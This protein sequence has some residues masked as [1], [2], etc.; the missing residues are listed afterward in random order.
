MVDVRRYAFSSRGSVPLPSERAFVASSTI[1]VPRPRGKIVGLSVGVDIRHSYTSD[2][3]LQL[4]SPGGKRVLLV[5]GRGGAGDDF[6]GTVFDDDAR[7][8]IASGTPP[9]NGKYRPEGRLG[10]L[11]GEQCAGTWTLR[12]EDR[13]VVDGGMLDGW[14]LSVDIEASELSV[15]IESFRL[16]RER[17]RRAR[18]F[19]RMQRYI[20][21]VEAR[22]GLGNVDAVIDCLVG[23]PGLRT[24]EIPEPPE[25]PEPLDPLEAEI[26]EEMLMRMP[27]AERARVLADLRV[28]HESVLERAMAEIPTRAP[29]TPP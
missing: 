14:T 29:T 20:A 1:V 18:A 5:D 2:L 15:D 17:I 12:V 16:L 4:V 21:C 22:G 11:V 6:E 10:S 27:A 28:A 8:P 24:I 3:K 13:A 7:L 25:P 19:K 9:F 26:L 23:E